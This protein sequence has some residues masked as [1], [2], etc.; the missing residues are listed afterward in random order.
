[1]YLAQFSVQ[2]LLSCQN[3]LLDKKD[4]ISKALKTFQKEEDALD[5]EIARY[6]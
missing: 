4:V 2:Y 3:S 6:K 1:M 5:L